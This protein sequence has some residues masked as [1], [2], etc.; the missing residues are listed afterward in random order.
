M[1]D[2]LPSIIFNSAVVTVAPSNIL[3]SAGVEVIV[4]VAATASKA[5]WPDK[6]GNVIVLSLS[7][8][9]AAVSFISWSSALVPSNCIV[10]FSTTDTVSFCIVCVPVTTKLP[11]IVIVSSASPNVTEAKFPFKADFK[12]ALKSLG[13]NDSTSPVPVVFLPNTFWV[14]ICCIL[15]R[16]TAS[17]SILTVRTPL[18]FIL[19]APDPSV[20]LSSNVELST[21][22]SISSALA[23]IPSP[24]TTFSVCVW[25][26][27]VVA[28]V[29]VKPAPA[30]V[31]YTHL[32][33][34]TKR[35]V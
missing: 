12:N 27:D 4:S 26:P 14:A 28:S 5:A 25:V 11:G 23:V 29:P 33:L 17:S 3:S 21:V 18:S 7:V 2:V 20:A 31:S 24:P 35:I 16:V 9:F 34:P 22:T 10:L 19:T 32:T 1:A 13:L 15:A 30:A 8:A 6:F